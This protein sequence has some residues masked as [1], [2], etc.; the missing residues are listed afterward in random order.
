M[1][2]PEKNVYSP[3]K[4]NISSYFLLLP[5]KERKKPQRLQCYLEE[6]GPGWEHLTTTLQEESI[7]SAKY[8]TV[9]L[10]SIQF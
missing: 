3:V 8:K 9:T 1:H 4:A 10:F 6:E 5:F 7:W 2:T